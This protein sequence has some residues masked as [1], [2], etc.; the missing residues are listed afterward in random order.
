MIDDLDYIKIIDFGEAKIV[1]KYE[2][3]ESALKE[4]IAIS[5]DTSF[6]G[7]L[8]KEKTIREKSGTFVGT[9][10][11]AAPEM[12]ESNLSGFYTDLWALGTIIY[13]MATGV[14]MFKAKNNREIFDKI[15]KHE[16]YYPEDM[17][18]DCIDLIERLCVAEPIQ[19]LGYKNFPALRSHPFFKDTNWDLIR[20][21]NCPLPD[22]LPIT[23]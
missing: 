8:K 2:E 19:R 10:F 18:K 11:Y 23:N 1:D 9:P 3:D 16:I 5:D 12:L 22:N 14:K 20:D 6:F 4:S 15:L 7:R 21:Q 17:D 13:E